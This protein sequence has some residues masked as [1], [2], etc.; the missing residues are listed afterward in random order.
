[1]ARLVGSFPLT[2][3]RITLQAEETR[4]TVNRE[5]DAAHDVPLSSIKYLFDNVTGTQASPSGYGQ[6][7]GQHQIP[8][9]PMTTPP[10]KKK[11]HVLFCAA[12][13]SPALKAQR[14]ALKAHLEEY[15]HEYPLDRFE[16]DFRKDLS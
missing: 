10:P 7:R 1:M 2:R 5:L 3:A 9:P 8:S 13:M 6:R 16:G 11:T 12:E 15:G 4:A 14:A